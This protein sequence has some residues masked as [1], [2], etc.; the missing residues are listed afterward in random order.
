MENNIQS[1]DELEKI[2]EKIR[3]KVIRRSYL[4][5]LSHVGSNLSCVRIL[6]ALYFSVME[7]QDRFIMSKGHAAL[8]L[9]S[10]LSEKGIL[11]PEILEGFGKK[12]ETHVSDEIEGV[13][14]STG[15][16]GHGLPIALG[17]ALAN[18]FSRIFVLLSDGELNEGSN[19][20]AFCFAAK[21]PLR[22]QN[23]IAVIDNNGC[24]A[25][26]EIEIEAE[27]LAIQALG[28]EVQIIQDRMEDIVSSLG[29]IEG[30][31]HLVVVKT[32]KGEGVPALERDPVASHYLKLR[33]KDV[34]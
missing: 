19:W 6:T 26:K 28:W 12:I 32:R 25:L 15:S 33:E 8:A 24:D 3:K 20:E 29:R 7:E 1:L 18:E 4:N 31:P 34:N 14:I 13:E 11:P 22:F 9:Y 27:V 10:V 30:A 23:L 16:L 21:N 2:A 5:Q 17:M